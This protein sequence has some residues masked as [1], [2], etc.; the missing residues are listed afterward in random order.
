MSYFAAIIL[1]NVTLCQDISAD[2]QPFCLSFGSA[3]FNEFCSLLRGIIDAKNCIEQLQVSLQKFINQENNYAEKAVSDQTQQFIETL[4]KVMKEV[5]H[6]ESD[7]TAFFRVL[8]KKLYEHYSD[9]L[10]KEKSIRSELDDMSEEALAALH[11]LDQLSKQIDTEVSIA[12][13]QR[14]LALIESIITSYFQI[15]R[16]YA[17]QYDDLVEHILQL[18]QIGQ[19]TFDNQV[20]YIIQKIV[21]HF[22]EKI[23]SIA[24]Q[25]SCV[26]IL[27]HSQVEQ[28]NT[29]VS[30]LLQVTFDDIRTAIA[31]NT[32]YYQAYIGNIA[33]QSSNQT[34]R[35]LKALIRLMHEYVIWQQKEETC[36]SEVQ[37]SVY[38]LLCSK[39]G[40]I[41]QEIRDNC[42]GIAI[43]IRSIQ[44]ELLMAIEGQ[45]D[46]ITNQLIQSFAMVKECIAAVNITM[47]TFASEVIN[48][49]LG[50]INNN[51]AVMQERTDQLEQSVIAK[52]SD[53]IASIQKIDAIISQIIQTKLSALQA[54]VTKDNNDLN[55]DIVL[56]QSALQQQI[57]GE[58]QNMKQVITSQQIMLG[59]KMR[60]QFTSV[61]INSTQVK[62]ALL[63]S[64]AQTE[65]SLSTK[66]AA[67][68]SSL[69][70]NI[71]DQ[72][73]NMVIQLTLN[74]AEVI[75]QLQDTKFFLRNVFTAGIEAH[76][77]HMTVENKIICSK[78]MDLEM[79]LEEAFE[80]L[81]DRVDEF[82]EGVQENI[83][84]TKED[85]LSSISNRE[86]AITAFLITITAINLAISSIVFPQFLAESICSCI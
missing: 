33:E 10:S 53:I 73:N 34:D 26:Y 83:E 17:K 20:S 56:M 23:S 59:D 65:S 29:E 48:V 31:C 16:A 8:I 69:E 79:Q 76:D 85:I 22:D 72:I 58:I 15:S 4:Q 40:V 49:S 12:I 44:S 6:A 18:Q 43:Q 7:V 2:H 71:N 55:R 52:S 57:C 47:Q 27:L 11:S 1:S 84:Q 74:R 68:E 32:D 38:E 63:C 28:L 30:D 24:S 61:S 64:M 46:T 21:I 5:E 77:I 80:S 82:T 60:D 66:I 9:A 25:L 75:D 51:A 62:N 36:I 14:Q 35:I 50:T 39:V 81:S 45:Y 67:I 41:N 19:G 70:G 3:D 13:G 42:E 78:L 54:Q 86:I 37:A